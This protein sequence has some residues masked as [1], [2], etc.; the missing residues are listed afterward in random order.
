MMFP[1]GL[2]GENIADWGVTMALGIAGVFCCCERYK[3]TLRLLLLFAGMLR[4]GTAE[5]RDILRLCTAG[6]LVGWVLQGYSA[7]GY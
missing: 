3:N 4:L 2:G 5:C 1:G 6:I 7:V